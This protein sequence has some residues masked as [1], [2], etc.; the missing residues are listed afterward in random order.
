MNT[1]TDSTSASQVAE[2]V[3]RISDPARWLAIVGLFADV[4]EA[5]H[6][7][8]GARVAT[9]SD[10]TKR[11]FNNTCELRTVLEEVVGNSRG[12]GAPIDAL[13]ASHFLGIAGDDGYKQTHRDKALASAVRCVENAL[14]DL[15][16]RPEGAVARRIADGYVTDDL[17]DRIAARMA[18]RASTS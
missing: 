17:L 7:L 18:E 14:V 15:L 10:E 8:D 9:K 2:H 13:M 3:A 5:T 4:V 1:N 16:S 6:A 12:C 11:L